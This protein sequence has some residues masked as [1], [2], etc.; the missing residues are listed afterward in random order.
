MLIILFHVDCWDIS[1]RVCPTR[2]RSGAVVNEL[3]INPDEES[4]CPFMFFFGGGG[5]ISVLSD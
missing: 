1:I 3:W 4:N 5:S 2:V